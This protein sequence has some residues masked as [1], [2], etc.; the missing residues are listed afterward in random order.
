MPQNSVELSRRACPAPVRHKSRRLTRRSLGVFLAWLLCVWLA[1]VLAGCCSTKVE[2]WADPC[3]DCP[4]SERPA[5]V[6]TPPDFPDL[7]LDLAFE[8]PE[9]TED[10]IRADM[11]GYHEALAR[12]VA[13]LMIALEQARKAY[14]DV[15]SAAARE[16]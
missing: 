6:W 12:D 16:P 4:F 13:R 9:W 2:P 5:P 14:E 11:E 10:E 15:R 3:T 8:T 1:L 7:D